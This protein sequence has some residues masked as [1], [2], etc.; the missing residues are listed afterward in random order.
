MFTSLLIAALPQAALA[1]PLALAGHDRAVPS[2]VA[3]SAG[4]PDFKEDLKAAGKD[5]VKLWALYEWALEDDERKKYRKRVLKAIVKVDPDHAEAR[6]ALGHVAY[7][8][9]W[10]DSERKRDKYVE[11]VA[12]ERGYVKYDGKWV[13]PAD[14]PFLEKGME[15]DA[16]GDWFDPVEKQ[17]LADGWKKQD[18]TWVEPDELSKMDEGLWKCDDKWLSLADANTFHDDYESPWRI[19]TKRAVVWSTATRETA[20]LAAEQADQAWYDMQKVFGFG[21]EVPIPFMVVQNE[22]Q[23]LQFMDGSEEYELPQLDPLAMSAMV[24]S[25]FA[26]LWFDFENE[27]YHGMGVTYWD[28][29]NPNG[30]AFGKHDARF[31]Y[32]LSFVE[33]VDPAFGVYDDVFK[34]GEVEPQFV[35]D[36]INAHKL[37][38]WF[39]WGAANY[40]SRW[41]KD[42]QVQKGGD[43]LWAFKWS[44]SNLNG[45]G[46]MSDLGDVFEFEASAQNE[47]TA[48]LILTAGLLVAYIVDGKDPELSKLHSQLQSAIEKREDTE[49]IFSS[50]RKALND[51]EEKIRAFA[52]V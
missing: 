23:Y 36:R 39:R 38:R 34:A 41:F 22:E 3:V 19:P 28:A 44:A 47:N 35:M 14:V 4:A 26:D 45:Q 46:G 21:G 51:Q 25:S 9:K 49:K 48:T 20:L 24:R 6:E 33:S 50:I 2:A 12:K 16:K 17:R 18:L 43:P 32:G 27:S 8:D 10:F 13:P 37:P 29:D 31:A 5:P 1:S 7:E 11:K 30:A 52:G 40:A 42:N 15:R